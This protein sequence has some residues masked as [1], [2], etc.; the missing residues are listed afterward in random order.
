MIME[1]EGASLVVSHME[2]EVYGSSKEDLW[3]DLK[4]ISFQK[5]NDP[6]QL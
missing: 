6:A 3:M 2:V 4:K 5:S 1:V